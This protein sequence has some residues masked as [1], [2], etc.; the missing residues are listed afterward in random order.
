MADKSESDL[1]SRIAGVLLAAGASVRLGRPK[2]LVTVHAAPLVVHAVK[3]VLDHCDAGLTVVTGACHEEVAEALV[4]LPV[5]LVYHPG[6]REGI[7]ASI[8]CGVQSARHDAG[9][10]LLCLCDQPSVTGE[11]FG[12]LLKAW[13]QHPDRIAAAGYAGISGVPA[14]FPR[15][16]WPALLSLDGDRGAKKIINACEDVISVNMPNAEFDIDTREQ[17]EKLD[18]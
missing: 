13:R 15:Q 5:T 18:I 9:A 7:G 16:Y 4:G 17:L 10:I 2:Q 14:L 3:Q 11:D 1:K 6:W 12:N 8:R